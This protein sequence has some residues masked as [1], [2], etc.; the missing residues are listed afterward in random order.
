MALLRF[1]VCSHDGWVV[2]GLTGDL[3]LAASHELHTFLSE[4]FAQTDRLLVDLSQVPFMDT[5]AL[6][7]LIKLHAR[8]GACG[9]ELRLAAPQPVVCKL[10][11][12]TGADQLPP[13]PTVEAAATAPSAAIV[14]PTP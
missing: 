8:A 4:V 5:H 13:F 3:D 14:D 10:L 12:H 9:G 1:T 11:A 7:V 2:T 6:D